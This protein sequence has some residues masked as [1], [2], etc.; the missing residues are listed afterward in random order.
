MRYFKKA[1]Y[2]YEKCIK[3]DNKN[4]EAYYNYSLNLLRAKNFSKGWDF[5]NKRWEAFPDIFN[6]LKS[7]KPL[8][9]DGYSKKV[10][11]GLNKV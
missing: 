6:F 2:F 8:W 11:F 5:Y 10:L 3:F 4:Y 9:T 7:E 1:N